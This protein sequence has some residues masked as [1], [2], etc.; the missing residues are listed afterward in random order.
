MSFRGYK[1][2]NYEVWESLPDI[3][4]SIKDAKKAKNEWDLGKNAVIESFNSKNKKTKI[5]NYKRN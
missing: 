3:F 5:I 2:V 4:S 1:V